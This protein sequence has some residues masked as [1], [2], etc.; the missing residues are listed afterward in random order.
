LTQDCLVIAG[1][2]DVIDP[3][4]PLA[5]FEGRKGGVLQVLAKTSGEQIAAWQLESPPVFDGVSAAAGRVLVAS[6]DGSVTCFVGS[7]GDEK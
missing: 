4:D 3:D 6:E 7:K 2:P 1:P 5:A